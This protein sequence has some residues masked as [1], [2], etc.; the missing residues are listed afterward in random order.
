MTTDVP[1]TIT[2]VECGGPARR[3]SYTPPDEGFVSGDIVA[4]V[5]VDCSQRLDLVFEES[6][7]QGD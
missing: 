7:D 6:E 1:D 4:Y 5:C 2:C 3:I